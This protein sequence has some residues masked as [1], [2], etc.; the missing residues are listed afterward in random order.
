MTAPILNKYVENALARGEKPEQVKQSLRMRGFRD[1][2]I[3]EAFA[4]VAPVPPAGGKQAQPPV[5]LPTGSASIEPASSIP[6]KPQSPPPRTMPPLPKSADQIAFEATRATYSS[7]HSGM[8]KI[9]LFVLLAI[10][11]AAAGVAYLYMNQLLD[12]FI[13]PVTDIGDLG[14]VPVVNNPAV[15]PA[16]ASSSPPVTEAPPVVLSPTEEKLQ[17]I[18]ELRILLV[19]AHSK[20]GV[21]PQTLSAADGEDVFYCYR[22]NGTH[23]ILG[24]VLDDENSTALDNDLDGNYLCGQ[25]TQNC[26]DPVYCVG[27]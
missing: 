20:N 19:T 10:V 3:A 15:S 8:K 22:Q 23:Y 4:S 2:D 7:P 26:A 5:G 1:E 11:L 16:P 6:P 12:Y 21:Y 27:P 25:T 14:P 18:D 24:A 17:M 9:I 13:P